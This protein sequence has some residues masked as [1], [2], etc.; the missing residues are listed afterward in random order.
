MVFFGLGFGCAESHL[1]AKS[2]KTTKQVLVKPAETF[3]W[4]AGPSFDKFR[5]NDNIVYVGDLINGQVLILNRK[6]G[7]VIE[8]IDTIAGSDVSVDAIAIGPDTAVDLAGVERGTIYYTVISPAGGIGRI[9]PDGS[10]DIVLNSG[11]YQV[12][13]TNGIAFSPDGTRLFVSQINNPVPFG[14]AVYEIFNFAD[15]NPNA[16]TSAIIPGTDNLEFGGS[17]ENFTT[18]NESGQL[19]IYGP[20]FFTGDVVKINA[21]TGVFTIVPSDKYPIYGPSSCEF[22]SQGRLWVSSFFGN[23]YRINN[24]IT[25][26][27]ELKK[28]CQVLIDSLSVSPRKSHVVYAGGPMAFLDELDCSKEVI[29]RGGLGTVTGLMVDGKDL[30]LGKAFVLGVYDACSGKQKQS[31]TQSEWTEV[32][33]FNFGTIMGIFGV[34]NFPDNKLLVS[35]PFPTGRIAIFSKNEEK[36]LQLSLQSYFLTGSVLP[37]AAVANSDGSSIFIAGVDALTGQGVV[38]RV[39]IDGSLQ[40]INTTTLLNTLIFPVSLALS[41]D[42]Q[43]LYVSDYFGGTITEV[44]SDSVI[45]TGLVSI[46]GISLDVDE[47]KLLF[48]QESTSSL[49]SVDVTTGATKRIIDKLGRL[50]QRVPRQTFPAGLI[51]Q[52]AVDKEC[53]KTLY[54]TA[55]GSQLVWKINAP[56]R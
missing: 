47:T 45:K 28:R 2:V 29:S 3:N 16:V 56:S 40:V 46:Q 20:R 19:Y 48:L 32:E 6:T 52:V 50:N 4:A 42:E 8:K 51:A 55:P 7:D 35:S 34:S 41:S 12:G 22:D 27:T 18:R 25:G 54:V 21:D 37:F 10:Q 44:F 33:D 26:K 11:P 53:P 30:L 9:F 14:N 39:D 17:L 1:L 5:V 15:P 23:I 36:Q 49:F 24:L 13:F 31:I 38:Q 43:N